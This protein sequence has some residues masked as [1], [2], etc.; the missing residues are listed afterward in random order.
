MRHVVLFSD[1]CD[2]VSFSD[3]SRWCVYRRSRADRVR[4]GAGADGGRGKSEAS[5]GVAEKS[6]PRARGS[7]VGR[8]ELKPVVPEFA[9][10]SV[11]VE[12]GVGGVQERF[13]LGRV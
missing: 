9:R 12:A 10:E 11:G 7:P 5:R 13:R 1:G 2:D 4:A 6:T 3:V 8:G